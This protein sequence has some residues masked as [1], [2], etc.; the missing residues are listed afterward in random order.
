MTTFTFTLPDELLVKLNNAAKELCL[1]KNKIIERALQIYLDQL[2]RA[3][4]VKSYKLASQ[5][6]DIVMMAEEGVGD[7]LRY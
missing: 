3:E 5:D 1:P 6:E 4:Y 2:K 7:M